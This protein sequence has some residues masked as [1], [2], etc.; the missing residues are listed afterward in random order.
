MMVNAATAV[1]CQQTKTEHREVS[2]FTKQ[3]S[4]SRQNYNRD[5]LRIILSIQPMHDAELGRL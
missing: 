1:V 4:S 5:S 2:L 3:V